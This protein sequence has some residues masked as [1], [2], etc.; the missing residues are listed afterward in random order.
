MRP[1]TCTYGRIIT[2]FVQTII[3]LEE[4]LHT[5]LYLWLFCLLNELRLVGWYFC[6]NLGIGTGKSARVNRNLE[7]S[8]LELSEVN[9][10]TL[11]R[12]KIGTVR[13]I[14]VIRKFELSE[15][16]LT[17][18]NCISLPLYFYWF[19]T[20]LF[21]P[22][23]KMVSHEVVQSEVWWCTD[24]WESMAWRVVFMIDMLCRHFETKYPLLFIGDPDLAKEVL[25]KQFAVF[26]NR[27]VSQFG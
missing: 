4:Y 22:Y 13:K 6:M 1:L 27:R 25:V 7:L 8:N 26:P 5:A 3:C 16:E 20:D 19:T 24:W 2:L 9:L 11:W 21:K 10:V 17:R 14:R 23:L 15:F 18:F 12:K